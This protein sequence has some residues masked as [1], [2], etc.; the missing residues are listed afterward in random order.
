M[1]CRRIGMAGIAF[2]VSNFCVV[3]TARADM[4]TATS[5]TL[6]NFSKVL[7]P[8]G[9]PF[10]Y[11]LGSQ[12]WVTAVF[13]GTPGASTA[14]LTLTT[15]SWAGVNTP[16]DLNVTTWGFNSSISPSNV[17]VVYSSGGGTKLV[18]D[19]TRNEGLD[20]GGNF[21]FVL[22]S[23]N[24]T[25]GI[26]ANTTQVYAITLSGG[27]TYNPAAFDQLSSKGTGLFVAY[28][29]AIIQDSGGEDYVADVAPEPSRLAG[30]IGLGVMGMI[31][32]CFARFAKR[33]AV[34]R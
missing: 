14:T 28:S 18:E 15:G 25:A 1:I 5:L 10:P 3:G 13:S 6:N 32:L 34:S 21:G 27:A 23:G 26:P 30:L 20:S 33:K 19:A 16:G 8:P 7:V 29:E 17:S 11:D 9:R 2:L 4:L 31:G 22:R 12:P 24:S